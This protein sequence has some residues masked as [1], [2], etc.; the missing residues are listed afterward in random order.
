MSAGSSTGQQDMGGTMTP[1][2]MNPSNDSNSRPL[3]A[4]RMADPVQPPAAKVDLS[5]TKALMGDDQVILHMLNRLTYGPRPGDVERLRKMGLVAWLQ[6]QLEPEKIDDS[7]LDQRLAAY[8][9][10]QMN[11]ADLMRHY[12]DEQMIRQAL[13]GT[14]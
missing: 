13:S 8:P 14:A 1:A 9:A 3:P 10:M 12:P 5:Q 7:A 4:I 6:Q 11:L 2:P